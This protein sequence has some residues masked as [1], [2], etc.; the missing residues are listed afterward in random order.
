MAKRVAS[1][2]VEDVALIEL[3]LIYSDCNSII[4][5]FQ[6]S[7]DA[8]LNRVAFDDQTRPYEGC[9]LLIKCVLLRGTFGDQT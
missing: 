3:H 4:A 9:I 2:F 8:P 5:L 7:Q 6:F 1:G